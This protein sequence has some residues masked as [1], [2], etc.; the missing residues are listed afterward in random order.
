M[1]RMNSRGNSHIFHRQQS[2]FLLCICLYSVFLFFFSLRIVVL[3]FR[4]LLL[5]R[6]MNN[7]TGF[8][9]ISP[10][11]NMIAQNTSRWYQLQLC[12]ETNQIQS[13]IYACRIMSFPCKSRPIIVDFNAH[14]FI[15]AFTEIVKTFLSPAILTAWLE[16]VHGIFRL[17][18][19]IF[20]V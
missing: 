14:R 19:C 17:E 16:I 18:F 15:Y 7:G 8:Y 6:G 3:F 1:V 4:L 13:R 9:I 12:L 20:D 10:Y 2:I 11:E 5:L